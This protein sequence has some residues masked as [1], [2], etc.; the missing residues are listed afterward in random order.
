MSAESYWIMDIASLKSPEITHPKQ[1]NLRNDSIKLKQM[2]K[3]V[4][5]VKQ[6][7]SP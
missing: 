4:R 7:D 3:E 6:S 5:Q 2:Q 1:N